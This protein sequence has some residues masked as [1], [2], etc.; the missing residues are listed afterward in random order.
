MILLLFDLLNVSIK[1]ML[2]NSF[3]QILLSSSDINNPVFQPRATLNVSTWPYHSLIAG[4]IL[5]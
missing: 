3:A 2:V 4:N 5:A 1:G